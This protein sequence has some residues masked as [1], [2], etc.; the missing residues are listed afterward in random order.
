MNIIV[1]NDGS[2]FNPSH[3][4]IVRIKE[5]PTG[6]YKVVIEL[7]AQREIAIDCDSKEEAVECRSEIRGIIETFLP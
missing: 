3:F 5:F 7:L 2:F 1:L 6:Q 4:V